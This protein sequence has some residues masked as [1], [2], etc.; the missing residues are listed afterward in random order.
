MEDPHGEK[1]ETLLQTLRQIPE[2]LQEEANNGRIDLN[3]RGANNSQLL[4]LPE[5]T[6]PV[7]GEGSVLHETG[8]CGELKCFQID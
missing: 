3:P 2:R 7:C 6:N 1:L 5:Q 8:E 4:V